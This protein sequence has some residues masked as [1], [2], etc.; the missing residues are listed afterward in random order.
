MYLQ[1]TRSRTYTDLIPTRRERREQR[2]TERERASARGSSSA[3]W[4]TAL[5]V[6]VVAVFLIA[7]AKA[8]GV[9]DRAVADD[10]AA[11]V[12]PARTGSPRVA[13]GERVAPLE[14]TH[15]PDGQKASYNSIP[16]TSGPH[17][18]APAPWGVYEQGLEDERVV[19]NQEHGGA[20]ISYNAISAFDLNALKALRNRYPPSRFGTVKIVIRGYDG[21]DPGTIALTSWLYRDTLKSYD[22]KRIL[23]F[24]SAHIDECCEAVP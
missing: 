16:P 10:P 13:V 21:I 24:L 18:A 20:T 9:F 8:F 14:G 4:F 17:W 19:H 15:I 6:A 1:A 23:S 22:E 5:V 3:P 7:G 12:T 2:R 11:S